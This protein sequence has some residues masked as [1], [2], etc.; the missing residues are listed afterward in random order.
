MIDGTIN[1][2]PIKS[3]HETIKELVERYEAQ[4]LEVTNATKIAKENWVG[5]GRNEFE[6]QYDILISKVDDFGECLLEIYEAL[7]MADAEY[8]QTDKILSQEIIEA[9]ANYGGAG[10]TGA[11]GEYG[12]G[13][14]TGGGATVGSSVGGGR[15]R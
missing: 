7:V 12:T 6:S 8:N 3:A 15:V 11:A 14:T 10:T 5:K 2:K 4:K 13:V 1:T 9:T